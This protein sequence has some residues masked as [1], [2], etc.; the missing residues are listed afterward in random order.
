MLQAE[1]G[2]TREQFI[3]RV[4]ATANP[5]SP[6]E[7]QRVRQMLPPVRRRDQAVSKAA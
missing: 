6:T 2:E 1:A 3:R 5:L 4:V 7:R